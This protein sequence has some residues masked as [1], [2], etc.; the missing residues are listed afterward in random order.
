MTHEIDW[1][2]ASELAGICGTDA[3][4]LREML[5]TAGL[6]DGPEPSGL[7]MRHGFAEPSTEEA[8]RPSVLW[9]RDV[10]V[11][12]R[13]LLDDP[14]GRGGRERIYSPGFEG[15]LDY[16]MRKHDETESEWSKERY[17]GY[18][19]EVPCP[20][21]HGARLKPEVLA[22]RVGDRSIAQLCDLPVGEARET[23][24]DLKLTGQAAKIAG[25][26][27][28]EINARL[29]F[30]V[31]VGLDYLSLSRG[32]ATLSGG[33]AQRIRLATQIGSG[34]V[35][36]LYVLDEPSIGLHQRDNAR[37]IETLERLRDLG[38]TLIVV[39]HDEDTIRSADWIVDIGPGAGE[40]GGEIVYSG[41]GEGLALRDEP[42]APTPTPR[43]KVRMNGSDLRIS[44]RR[45]GVGRGGR[46]E[47]GYEG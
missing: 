28:A 41:A 8:G 13:G 3:F 46:A 14:R 35:G 4:A 1:L 22:V 12:L 19:R 16:V 25:S 27:L 21:C 29:G 43:A 44:P 31:D 17:Q 39:E 9:H 47:A 5:E 15:V 10:A 36:V 6:A 7:A 18:M 11:I 34:L 30:L 24:R 40:R 32:A 2:T 45:R 33:E 20:A 37:L 26:V 38:N 23:L 42:E